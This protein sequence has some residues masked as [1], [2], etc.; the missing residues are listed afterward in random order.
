MIKLLD[1]HLSN[2]RYGC[3]EISADLCMS[4]T[5]AYRKIK[6]LTGLSPTEFIRRYRLNQACQRLRSTD[7][8]IATIAE[9]SG[10]S[11]PSYFT[12]SFVKE[13][14]KTPTEYRNGKQ[15]TQEP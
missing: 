4:Y 13:F 12:A 2:E 11:T 7:L 1:E 5:T 3:V 8:P 10:F 14:G 15:N 6:T 9:Q